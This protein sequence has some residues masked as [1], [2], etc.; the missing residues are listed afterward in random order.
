MTGGE[1][2]GGVCIQFHAKH[3][4]PKVF[5]IGSCLIIAFGYFLNGPCE[6]LPDSVVLMAIGNFLSG[7]AMCYQSV[8]SITE[9]AARTRLL[10]PE[11]SDEISDFCAATLNTFIGMGQ[12]LGPVYGAN[13]TAALGFRVAQDG[14][15]VACLAY[16]VLYFFVCDG[17]TALKSLKPPAESPL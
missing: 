9:L 15:S 13:M 6:V 3:I 12:A 4:E 5:L 17:P 14:V 8:Y 10:Y 1:F 2:L 7:F 11:G 16:A